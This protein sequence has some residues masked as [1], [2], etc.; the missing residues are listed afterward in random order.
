MSDTASLSRCVTLVDD[1]PFALDILMRA[2]R[3]FHFD[4]QTA[5][6]AED[7]LVALEKQP[8]PVVVTGI[9]HAGAGRRLAGAGDQET[10]AADRRHRGHRRR[11]R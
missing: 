4:C 6:S 3:S 8:T 10:L 5:C 2:A 7:A 9:A 1:E 11:R